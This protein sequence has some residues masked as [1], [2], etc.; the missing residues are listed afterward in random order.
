MLPLI[1]VVTAAVGALAAVSISRA[2]RLRREYTDAMSAEAARL[3]WGYREEIAFDAIPDLTRFELF[4]RGHGRKLRHLVTTPPGDPRAVLFEY[5]YTISS[6][7]STTTYRQT[8]YYATG[9]A[10]RLPSFS[11][12][13]ENFFHRV[14]TIFGYQDINFEQRP[15]FS[16]MF[17][18]RG[19]DEAAVR[20]LFT[21]PVAEFF[22]RNPGVCAAGMGREL[23]FWR[24]KR[25]VRPPQLEAFI[26]EGEAVTARLLDTA[27]SIARTR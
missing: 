17:L 26:R 23:L 21:D 10:L 11:L 24:P 9:D 22:E 19:D 4:R 13:P 14:G 16:R 6:G 27:L 25:V 1:P 15:G 12:R 8:V 7:N 18:L 3:G 2:R 5:R 20:A